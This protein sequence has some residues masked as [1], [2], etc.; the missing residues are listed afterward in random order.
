MQ[1]CSDLAHVV[2]V[3]VR[4]V[5]VVIVHRCRLL[6]SHFV[7]ELLYQE[8]FSLHTPSVT[9]DCVDCYRY[10]HD[11]FWCIKFLLRF[12]PQMNSWLTEYTGFSVQSVFNPSLLVKSHNGD[13]TK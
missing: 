1:A 3:L 12:I 2:L 8:V 4:R 9:V 6:R 13:P 10:N 11:K 7:R 5:T